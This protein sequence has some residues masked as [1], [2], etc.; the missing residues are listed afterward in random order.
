MLLS[1]A[2]E[3]IRRREIF[4]ILSE[5]PSR[6]K[7]LI[8]MELQ[9]IFHFFCWS[10]KFLYRR[11]HTWR[12]VMSVSQCILLCRTRSHIIRN[13]I[14]PW[15]ALPTALQITD[16]GKFQIRA[17]LA[18][19][20]LLLSV[21]TLLL[22]TSVRRGGSGRRAR[23]RRDILSLCLFRSGPVDGTNIPLQSIPIDNPLAVDR[24]D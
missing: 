2:N 19:L 11:T 23:A 3:S 22:M 1:P 9:W 4:K 8:E 16:Y 21:I 5:F 6:W 20:F 18:Q 12:M 15:L 7:I 10:F 17:L 14:H 13:F 24:S